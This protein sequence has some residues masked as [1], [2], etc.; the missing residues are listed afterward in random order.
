MKRDLVGPFAMQ[1]LRKIDARRYER[2]R[3]ACRRVDDYQ[4]RRGILRA[5]AVREI[6]I[7]EGLLSE[8]RNGKRPISSKAWRK[9]FEAEKAAGI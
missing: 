1:W 5:P 6:G 4:H 7:S 2:R 3:D 8:I 9:L